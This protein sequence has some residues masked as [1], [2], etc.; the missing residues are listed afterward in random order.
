MRFRHVYMGL[1]IF[2]TLLISLLTDPDTGLV[3]ALPF[4]A[5]TVAT[6]VILLKAILYTGLLH[7]TRKGLLD[8]FNFEEFLNKAKLSSEG[9]GN[10]I[11]GVGLY[12]V[13]MAIVIYAATH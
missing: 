7:I 6:V 3:Q 2:F 5:G 11:I 8:Y 9:A 10:A 1:G 12:C 4:G 13:A